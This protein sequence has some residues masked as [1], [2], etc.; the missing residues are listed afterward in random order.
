M[1][2]QFEIITLDQLS[3]VATPEADCYI[4]SK[5]NDVRGVIAARWLSHRGKH[6]GVDF[7]DDYFSQAD[8]VRFARLRSWIAQIGEYSDF[9]L[10]ST[11]RM[12]EVIGGYWPAK[13][14]H[15]LNDPFE[16]LDGPA[17]R[18]TLATKLDHFNRTGEISLAWFGQ[19]RNRNFPVGLRDVVAFGR[20]LGSFARAGRPVLRIMTSLDAFGVNEL[21]ALGGLGIPYRLEEWSEEA[22][23]ALLREAL[24]VVLPVNAQAFSQ[25][26]S[27]NRAVTALT[28]G[29][30]VLSL[31]HDL[32]AAFGPLIYRDADVLASDL[33]QGALRLRPDTVVDLVDL[34][35]RHG[36]PAFEAARLRQF[37]AGVMAA[38]RRV[39]VSSAWGAPVI[40]SG[41]RPSLDAQ[42][43]VKSLGGLTLASPVTV[44]GKGHDVDPRR[45]DGGSVDGL[46]RLTP[47]AAEALSPEFKPFLRNNGVGQKAY[48]V[49]LDVDPALTRPVTPGFAAVAVYQAKIAATAALARRLFPGSPVFVTDTD[50]FVLAS[51]LAVYEAP[52]PRY[53]LVANGVTPTLQ[54]SFLKP[55]AAEIASGAVSVDVLTELDIAPLLQKGRPTDRSLATV[56]DRITRFRPDVLVFS[57]YSGPHAADMLRLARR[58]GSATVMH[59]DDDLLNVPPEIGERKFRA[60]NHPDRTGAVRT[61]LDG[62]DLVYCSTAPLRRRF[63]ELG[64]TTPM[65]S[66]AIYCAAEPLRAPSPT[67]EKRFGYMGFDHEHDLRMVLPVIV[68]LLETHP[69]LRFE[70]F[71][72]IPRPDE[73]AAFGERVSMV[74]PV[75]DYASFLQALADRRWDIG[76]CPLAPLPFNRLK[77]NTKWVEYTAAGAAVVASAGTVYDDC[78]A[79]GAG[80]L[81]T[82]LDDWFARLDAL[83]RDDDLRL[84]RVAAAQARLVADYGP[85]ALK[86]QVLDVFQMARDLAD[87][88]AAGGGRASVAAVA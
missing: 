83:V 76:I 30:Q 62:C 70:L 12:A 6:V 59:M 15:T 46:A 25:A 66:G 29:C 78:C 47:E 38:P 67:A 58:L 3:D 50:P 37:L 85:R 28:A 68:K 2:H 27:L 40:I 31:G 19:G 54:L 44:G 1:G 65:I 73:L 11:S 7:F 32:Y 42:A 14:I 36:D 77:A 60:H 79:D 74:E 52:P 39:P 5:C 63:Q 20:G 61:L 87:S 69:D 26:K 4:L 51:G 82:S 34:M 13:P 9:A 71:G 75:R 10:C 88:R 55:L 22:E 80:D 35:G 23:A 45:D 56:T 81:A 21:E 64:V 24:A 41:R 43:F 53:M 57:R 72:S 49:A 86:A 18:T 17:L 84:D 33:S 8:D 48:P 16:E